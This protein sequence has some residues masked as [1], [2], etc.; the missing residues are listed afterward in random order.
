MP[1]T[2][3]TTFKSKSK[4]IVQT[5]ENNANRLTNTVLQKNIMTLFSRS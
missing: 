2:Y 5:E 1:Q 3:F 4:I